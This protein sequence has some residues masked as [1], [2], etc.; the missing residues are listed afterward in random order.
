MKSQTLRFLVSLLVLCP[1]SGLAAD[2][3]TTTA[4]R[5]GH[6]LDPASGKT[7]ENAVVLVRDGRIVAVGSGVAIP[8]GGPGRRRSIS[9]ASPV[10]RG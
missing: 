8:S 4:L 6:L 7:T 3:P 10:C 2:A 9:P 5:C 1:A